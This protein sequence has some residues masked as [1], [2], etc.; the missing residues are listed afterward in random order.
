MS[1]QNPLELR[2]SPGEVAI[3]TTHKLLVER[4]VLPSCVNCE[5]WGE[6]ANHALKLKPNP[7]LHPNEVC[8]LWGQRPPAKV[9]V[10]GCD[11]HVP[12]IPF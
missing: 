2:R 9:I 12:D 11:R 8:T 10:V 7:Q 4:G 1:S 3:Y 5:L 6:N